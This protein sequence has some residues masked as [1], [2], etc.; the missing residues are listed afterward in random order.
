MY[1]LQVSSDGTTEAQPRSFLFFCVY[2]YPDIYPESR[3]RSVRTDL[4]LVH[5]ETDSE[6]I[7]G[8]FAGTTHVTETTQGGRSLSVFG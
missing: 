7:F 3:G 5:F 2:T 4:Q 6:Y 8:D 1:A